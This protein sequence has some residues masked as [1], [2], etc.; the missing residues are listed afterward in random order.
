M[1]GFSYRSG[2]LLRSDSYSNFG[3]SKIGRLIEDLESRPKFVGGP[4]QAEEKTLVPLKADLGRQSA[5]QRTW[6]TRS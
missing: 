4:L 2:P 6:N 1:R 5:T 3:G